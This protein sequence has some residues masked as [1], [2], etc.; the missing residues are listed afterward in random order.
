[1]A[2]FIKDKGDAFD[3]AS[4][5]LSSTGSE[6]T[7]S[8]FVCIFSQFGL[9]VEGKMIRGVFAEQFKYDFYKRSFCVM[10]F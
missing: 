4:P 6:V 10:R 9:K 8:L 2:W 5:A 1:M 3:P 7:S